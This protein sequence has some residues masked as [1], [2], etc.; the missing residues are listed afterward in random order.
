MR[1][2]LINVYIISTFI[3][4]K[5]LQIISVNFGVHAFL[6]CYDS[7]SELSRGNRFTTYINNKQRAITR[8]YRH[9][10]HFLRAYKNDT[11]VVQW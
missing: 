11:Q 10:T 8:I 2:S 3:N 7:L 1:P 9:E 4:L 5:I 6:V